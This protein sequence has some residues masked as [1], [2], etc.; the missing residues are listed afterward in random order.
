MT[1]STATVERRSGPRERWVSDAIIAGFVAI[2]ASTAA[3][4]IAYALASITLGI[5]IFDRLRDTLAE[6]I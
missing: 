1:E 6:A 5:T 2:G 3:L 4:M